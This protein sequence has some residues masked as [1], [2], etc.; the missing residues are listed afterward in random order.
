[1]SA[2]AAGEAAPSTGP[3]MAAGEAAPASGPMVAAGPAPAASGGMMASVVREWQQ[4]SHEVVH[5]R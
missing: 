1:M 5:E 2:V 3:V 4:A